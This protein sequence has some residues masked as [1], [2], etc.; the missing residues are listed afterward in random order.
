MDHTSFVKILNCVVESLHRSQLKI[1]LSNKMRP[2]T[3]FKL[4]VFSFLI[5]AEKKNIVLQNKKSY[6]HEQKF[7]KLNQELIRAENWNKK[8]SFS[9]YWSHTKIPALELLAL[10]YYAV[11]QLC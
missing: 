6:E 4:L 7:E 2:L 5:Q 9:V 8:N 10:V 3:Q 1:N 11:L